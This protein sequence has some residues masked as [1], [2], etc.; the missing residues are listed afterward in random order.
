MRISPSLPS[1][2]LDISQGDV[3]TTDEAH[4]AIY[5]TQLAVISII[6]LSRESRETHWHEGIHLYAG[7]LHPIEESVFYPP[8]PHIIIKQTN[9]HSLASLVDQDIRHEIAQWV[10]L[11]DISI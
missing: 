4:L 7:S 8:A 10:V 6:Y 1:R 11:D 9:L 5:H 3:H 2:P